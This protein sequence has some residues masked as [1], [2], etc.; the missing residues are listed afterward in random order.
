MKRLTGA[1]FGQQ[2]GCGCLT[3]T[4]RKVA[5]SPD[6]K[7]KEEVL[8]ELLEQGAVALAENL[9]QQELTCHQNIH[10]HHTAWNLQE[11]RR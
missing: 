7:I 4:D 6:A 8:V 11:G 9:L 5:F 2:E 10:V 1:L 3:Q